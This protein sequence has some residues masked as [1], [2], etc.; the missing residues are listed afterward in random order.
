MS[1]E[2]NCPICN[3]WLVVY[4]GDHWRVCDCV[5]NA[6]DT[7]MPPGLVEHIQAKIRERLAAKKAGL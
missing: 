3:D 4:A 7:P 5:N 6:D 2:P 1:D